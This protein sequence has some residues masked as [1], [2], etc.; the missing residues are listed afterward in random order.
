MKQRLKS[1][2][3]PLGLDKLQWGQESPHKEN[4]FCHMTGHPGTAEEGQMG[5]NEDKIQVTCLPSSHLGS[6]VT[7]QRDVS[8]SIKDKFVGTTN[9]KQ[10][11]PHPNSLLCILARGGRQPQPRNIPTASPQVLRHV[12]ASEQAPSGNLQ[13]SSGKRPCPQLRPRARATR[14]SETD[15]TTRWGLSQQTPSTSPGPLSFELEDFLLL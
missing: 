5:L 3:I 10:L 6:C 1:E 2:L 7:A 11:A 4:C 9:Y 15:Y 8:Q 14:A 12:A 13:G